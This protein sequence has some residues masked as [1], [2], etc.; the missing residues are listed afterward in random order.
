MRYLTNIAL[1][2][3]IVSKSLLMIDDIE[4][5]LDLIL[6]NQKK[7]AHRLEKLENGEGK[8]IAPSVSKEEKTEK[9]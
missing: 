2:D 8:S 4:K 7:L 6:E 9:P 5:K 1:C 3:I